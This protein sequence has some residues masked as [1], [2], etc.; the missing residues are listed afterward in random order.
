MNFKIEIQNSN[1]IFFELQD[2]ALEYCLEN[3]EGVGAR[4]LR[5]QPLPVFQ[6]V[7]KRKIL[8]LKKNVV[9]NLN[10]ESKT[11]LDQAYLK[12]GSYAKAQT[13]GGRGARKAYSRRY[14]EY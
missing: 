7:F 8:E 2:F 4:D 12:L 9:K 6:A 11:C 1:D 5:P 10:F 13:T 3:V 14:S